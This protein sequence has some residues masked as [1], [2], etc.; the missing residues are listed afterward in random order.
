M[1]TVLKKHRPSGLAVSKPY[2]SFVSWRRSVT[3]VTWHHLE[4]AMW[5]KRFA[6]VGCTADGTPSTSVWS[7]KLIRVYPVPNGDLPNRRRFENAALCRKG[8]LTWPGSAG[9]HCALKEGHA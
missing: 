4:R 2:R 7:R 3:P 5:R 9:D 6:E 1:A 8:V